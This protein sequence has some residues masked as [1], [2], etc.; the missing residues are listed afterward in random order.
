MQIDHAAVDEVRPGDDVA[1]KVDQR[2][3]AG[4]LVYRV[5]DRE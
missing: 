1:V 2:V 4:D 3:R 5:E